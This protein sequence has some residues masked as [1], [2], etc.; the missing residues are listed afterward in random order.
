MI[1]VQ[2]LRFLYVNFP[3][4]IFIAKDGS[5]QSVAISDSGAHVEGVAFSRRND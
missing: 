1:Y 2:S 4:I 3:V 5:V